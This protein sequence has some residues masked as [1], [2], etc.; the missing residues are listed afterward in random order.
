MQ[1]TFTLKA[2]AIVAFIAIFSE[3]GYCLKTI[4][5]YDPN[6]NDGVNKGKARS[7]NTSRSSSYDGDG[8]MSNGETDSNASSSSR[9]SSAQKKSNVYSL[10][11]DAIDL[12]SKKLEA[13]QK[14]KLE[15]LKNKRSTD[16][17]KNRTENLERVLEE[18]IKAKGVAED[19]PDDDMKNKKINENLLMFAVQ[20]L[21]NRIEQA[22]E[23]K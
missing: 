19:T 3:K 20:D 15:M 12:G 8:N 23:V 13:L 4:Q 14:K 1:K 11:E 16:L 21:T 5:A 2:I 7:S 10:A 9:S 22:N 6:V 18:T 17:V